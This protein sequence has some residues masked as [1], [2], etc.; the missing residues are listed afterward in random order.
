VSAA[1]GRDP[2]EGGLRAGL[3][4]VG[5]SAEVVPMPLGDREAGAQQGGGS[6]FGERASCPLG[7]CDGSGWVVGEDEEAQPCGCRRRKIERARATGVSAT[8][9]KRFRGVSFDRPPVTEMTGRPGT[10][11]V[12][13]DV[14]EFCERIDERLDAGQGLWLEGDPGTG[15]TTLAMLVSKAALDAGRTAAIYS[16]PGLLARIRRTYDGEAGEDSYFTFFN[17]LVSVDLLHLDDLGAESRSEWVLEQ[18]YAIVD[19]RYSDQRS[20]VVTTNLPLGELEQQIGARTVSRL[21]EICGEAI[22]VPGADHRFQLSPG[23]PGG[24]P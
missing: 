6:A 11:A 16:L 12:V 3:P 2:R 20:I 19:R 7:V 14:R 9:P 10:R 23:P 24:Q 13:A 18:L 17:R 5:E 22:N 1:P 21:V 4:D 15:K 8:L